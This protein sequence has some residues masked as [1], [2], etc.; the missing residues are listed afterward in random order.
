M[1]AFYCVVLSGCLCDS[2]SV[3]EV[4]GH[5]FIYP[6]KVLIL[7]KAN[8]HDHVIGSTLSLIDFFIGTYI[9]AKRYLFIYLLFYLM[10]LAGEACGL[11]DC[12]W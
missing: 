10:F 7:L 6:N 3:S 5:L 11:K 1:V 9:E 2:F 8:I 4:G 12:S